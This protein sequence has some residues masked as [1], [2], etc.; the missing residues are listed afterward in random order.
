MRDAALRTIVHVSCS[1]RTLLTEPRT[2]V[3]GG[4]EPTVLQSS[5]VAHM[6]EHGAC[7]CTCMCMY[8]DS[9]VVGVCSTA[10]PSGRTSCSV[11][12]V[13]CAVS[14]RCVVAGPARSLRRWHGPRTGRCGAHCEVPHAAPLTGHRRGDLCDHVSRF[15]AA[16]QFFYDAVPFASPLARGAA[17]PS[18]RLHILRWRS[19]SPLVPRRNPP[20]IQPKAK[21]PASS[22]RS[23]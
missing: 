15:P 14:G 6:H 3:D 18:T 13:V 5:T 11:A 23:F 21:G 12:R 9:C 8:V 17:D 4:P 16:F 7:M 10:S 2:L 22:S 19:A 20:Q 1:R